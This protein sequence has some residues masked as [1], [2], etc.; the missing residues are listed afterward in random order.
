MSSI[1]TDWAQRHLV[2]TLLAR[3]LAARFRGSLLGMGWM[4]LLPLMM[5]AVYTLVF[6]HFLNV[7]WNTGGTESHGLAAAL[8]IYL[9]LLVFNYAAEN[10]THAPYLVLEHTQFVKKIV[11]PLPILAYVAALAAL[12]PL[13]LGLLVV[14]LA[15][16]FLP[17]A[18]P[19]ALLALPLYWLPLPLFA[20]AAHWLFGAIGVYLRDLAHLLPPLTTILMFLSP[21]FYPASLIPPRWGWLFT[22]NPLTL[23]IENARTLLFRGELPPLAPTLVLL[24]IALILAFLARRLFVRLQPG[25]ADVL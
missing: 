11:F 24:T 22:L 15:A 5:V 10:L 14:A 6:D 1:L 23:P 4:L 9:G 2:G 13:V 21:I 17:D 18:H 8:N 3:R 7:R 16:S 12:V 20:L 25:F 19:F